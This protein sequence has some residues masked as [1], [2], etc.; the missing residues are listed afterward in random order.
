MKGRSRDD[1]GGPLMVGFVCVNGS[2]FKRQK[3]TPSL[4]HLTGEILDKLTGTEIKKGLKLTLLRIT[5]YNLSSMMRCT[6][7]QHRSVI[8]DWL[9]PTLSTIT[10]SSQS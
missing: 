9:P 4:P 5:P 1:D 8:D 6:D 10:H 2:K 3:G 7:N